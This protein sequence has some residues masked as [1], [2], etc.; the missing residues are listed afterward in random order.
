M[1]ASAPRLG[2]VLETSLYVHDLVTARRFYETVL[3]LAPMF[4]DQ[5][6]TA[7]PLAPGSVLLL[8][9]RGTSDRPV[10]LPG[11]IIPP[12]AG[13]GELHYALAIAAADLAAW[14]HHLEA[15]D[16]AIESELHWPSGAVSLYFR[17][18]DRHLVELATP[19]LWKNY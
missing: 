7:Y 18:P 8:F 3:G 9:E 17:D 13:S 15:H 16:V 5:R 2:G 11:G 12:H 1:T 14:R 10:E 6:L 19:G 4:E